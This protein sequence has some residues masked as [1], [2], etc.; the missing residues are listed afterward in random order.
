MNKKDILMIDVPLFIRLLEYAREDAKTDMDLHNVTENIIKLSEEEK[1]LTMNDYDKIVDV[2]ETKKIEE[3][4]RMK[5]L[6]GLI[7]ESDVSKKEIKRIEKQI[8]IL[9]KEIKDEKELKSELKKMKDG[10]VKNS[11]LS[12]EDIEKIFN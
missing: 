7:V 8:E 10:L 6:A 1:A 2:K 5:Q 9:K 4:F 11:E 12:K 3:N